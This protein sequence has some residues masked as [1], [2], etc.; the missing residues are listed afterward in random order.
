MDNTQSYLLNI[1]LV[2]YH[3]IFFIN[4]QNSWKLN[5][6]YTYKICICTKKIMD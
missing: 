2:F 4:N 6:V 3:K 1:L 5:I